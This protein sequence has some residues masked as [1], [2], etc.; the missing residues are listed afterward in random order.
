VTP[1]VLLPGMN[2]TADLWTGCGLGEALTPDLTEPSIEAQVD[3]LLSEL[4]SRFVLGGLS[5]GAI[6]AMALVSRAPERVVGLAVVST[7]AKAPTAAQRQ[8]WLTWM[9]RL[10]AGESPRE[11]QAEIVPALLSPGAVSDRADLVERTLAMGDEIGSRALRA[12]LRMQTTRTDLRPGLGQ[13]RIPTLVVSGTEDVI[14][15]PEFHTEIASAL[16]HG[17]VVTLEG[18]HLL[19]ME[20]SE[21]FGALVRSWCRRHGLGD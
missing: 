19:P 12:Q 9:T 13:V 18:G 16:P 15:P 4:P 7:N 2:C 14:C 21:A 8:S 10:N 20:R 17:R 1:L 11:L 3:R 5:L 6:V